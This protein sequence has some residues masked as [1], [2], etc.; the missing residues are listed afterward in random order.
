[1]QVKKLASSDFVAVERLHEKSAFDY[2]MP[3]LSSSLFKT[4]QGIWQGDRLIGAAALRLQAETYLWL[5]PDLPVRVR[6]KVIVALS[7]AIVS[8][9]WRM[10]LDCLSAWLPPG[11]PPSFH[12]FL[13]KL[14]WLPDRHGWEPWSNII[15]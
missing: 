12:K 2:K 6:Y 9:A 7:E 3:D 1:M 13:K 5:D 14:G 11:L 10:G 4:K 8:V 15:R